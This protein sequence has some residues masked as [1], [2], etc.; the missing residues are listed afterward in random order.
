[1][2]IT[3]TTYENYNDYPITELE[4]PDAIENNL[5]R[6]DVLTIGDVIERIENNTLEEIRNLGVS[7][8][9]KVKNALF[10][11][12]LSVAPDPIEF[13]LKCEVA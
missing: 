4:L 11:Y 9:K 1:M 6:G 2:N 12:E 8:I 13:I 5:R 7:K 10:N 3:F